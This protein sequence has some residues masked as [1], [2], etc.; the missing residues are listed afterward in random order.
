MHPER[1][2]ARLLYSWRVSVLLT[3]L[4]RSLEVSHG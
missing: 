3:E 1:K 4:A 2:S